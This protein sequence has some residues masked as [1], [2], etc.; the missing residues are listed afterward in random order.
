MVTGYIIWLETCEICSDWFDENYYQDCY[1]LGLIKNP[2]GPPKSNYS[3]EPY[4]KKSN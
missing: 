3:L 2:Q 1:N 4:E